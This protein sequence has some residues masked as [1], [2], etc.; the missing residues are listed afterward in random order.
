MNITDEIVERALSA[1]FDGYSVS[2]FI[3][4]KSPANVRRLMRAALQAAALQPKE[5]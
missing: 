2:S 4:L 1:P 3:P 5:P